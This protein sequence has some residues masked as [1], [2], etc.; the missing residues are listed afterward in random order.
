MFCKQ[1]V[2][3]LVRRSILIWVG[4]VCICPTKKMLGVY[5]LNRE[6]NMSAHILLFKINKQV[7]EKR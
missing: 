4:T 7:E 2:E 6:S 5:G 1:N 3:T